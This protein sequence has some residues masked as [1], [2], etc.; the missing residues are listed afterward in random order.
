MS[1]QVRLGEQNAE[2]MGENRG[3]MPLS[4]PIPDLAAGHVT[5]LMGACER[6]EDD[7]AEC[8]GDVNFV[9]AVGRSML[10]LN[11]EPLPQTPQRERIRRLFEEAR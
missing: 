4:S 3:L 8:A 2:T 11:P 7:K 9:E 10:D 5:G 6:G 1:E